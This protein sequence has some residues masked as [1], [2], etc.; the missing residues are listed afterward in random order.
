M[1]LIRSFLLY[2]LPHRDPLRPH[3][4]RL[5]L[6]ARMLLGSEKAGGDVE[7]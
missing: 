6:M 7:S 5:K 1:C 4:F 2:P 3:G